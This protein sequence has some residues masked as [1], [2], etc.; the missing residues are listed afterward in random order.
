MSILWVH[1][2]R[3]VTMPAVQRIIKDIKHH[4]SKAIFYDINAA[5]AIKRNE[6]LDDIQER[7]ASD[8]T[9]TVKVLVHSLA[10][11]TLKPYITKKPEDAVT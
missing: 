7:F 3:H 11:G 5:D 9:S 10:F 6:T 1:L 8:S 4:G 2:D